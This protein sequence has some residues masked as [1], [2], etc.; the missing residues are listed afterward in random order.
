[1]LRIYRDR[2]D[3]TWIETREG[4]VRYLGTDVE[5][6]KIHPRVSPLS[7]ETINIGTEWTLEEADATYELWELS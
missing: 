5:D 7:S 4:H 3:G 2:G 1:M 6:L